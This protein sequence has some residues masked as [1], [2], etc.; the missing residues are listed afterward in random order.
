MRKPATIIMAV[1]VALSLAGCATIRDSRL[2]P[3]NWFGR[4]E[5]TSV[6]VPETASG[7]PND[8]R[9]LVAQVTALE[10]A[11]MPGGAIVRAT[12]LPPT[13][14]WWKAELVAENGGDPVDGVMTYRFVL[15]PPVEAQP[16]STTQ[17]REVTA[18]AYLSNVKLEQ[19][20]TVV[21]I[22][23]TNSRSSRR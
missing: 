10:V 12:G 11:R 21:V 22:G 18:A 17:S 3:F 2:N 16:A 19:I 7:I 6:Q 1:A 13:Q 14:G 20:R 9:L 4:S 5:E 15:A 8:P 23:E